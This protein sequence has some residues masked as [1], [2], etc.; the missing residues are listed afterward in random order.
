MM[1]KLAILAIGFTIG[2]LIGSFSA[3][4]EQNPAIEIC[5]LILKGQTDQSGAASQVDQLSLTQVQRIDQVIT[6]LNSKPQ[7][8]QQLYD[9]LGKTNF[10]VL[11]QNIRQGAVPGLGAM[12]EAQPQLAR[13]LMDFIEF[14]FAFPGIFSNPNAASTVPHVLEL[15]RQ[16]ELSKDLNNPRV[17]ES[18]TQAPRLIRTIDNN[19]INMIEQA[20]NEYGTRKMH[21][22]GLE[23]LTY[24]IKRWVYPTYTAVHELIVWAQTMQKQLTRL[25]EIDALVI[26]LGLSEAKSL[27]LTNDEV[28]ELLKFVLDSPAEIRQIEQA[29]QTVLGKDFAIGKEID[30]GKFDIYGAVKRMRGLNTKAILDVFDKVNINALDHLDHILSVARQRLGQP[31]RTPKDWDE[32]EVRLRF[33]AAERQVM[34]TSENYKEYTA[35]D[36]KEEYKIKHH[37]P[38]VK[39]KD[40][41]VTTAAYDTWED[42]NP[43]FEEIFTDSYRTGDGA[44][45]L[46]E[47]RQN[48]AGLVAHESKQR[49]LIFK[50]EQFMTN[51]SDGWSDIINNGKTTTTSEKLNS[52]LAEVEKMIPLQLEYSKWQ[53]QKIHAQYPNDIVDNFTGRNGWMLSR[54][55]QARLEL[56]ALSELLRRPD[57]QMRPLYDMFEYTKWMY[58]LKTKRDWNYASKYALGAVAAAGGYA[59]L[60][61]EANQYLADHGITLP[62]YLNQGIQS[63]IESFR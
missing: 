49:D 46:S 37:H 8:Q 42:I 11:A 34:R 16:Q 52:F 59:V 56:I 26:K 23:N 35:Q 61:P 29:M 10:R 60:S 7:E 57:R 41:K 25:R 28:H 45:G 51:T 53:E 36:S 5:S 62:Q 39:D 24:K 18:Q 30:I 47:V 43:T 55:N 9:V 44:S 38:E 4:A 6:G 32:E 50:V 58:K 17:L 19:F 54:L 27:K 3:Q 13:L 2:I 63:L 1:K 33:E 22:T 12:F 21:S 20:S 31:A 48:A 40:G 14:G 15:S